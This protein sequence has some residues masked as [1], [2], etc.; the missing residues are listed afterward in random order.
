VFWAVVVIPGIMTTLLLAYPA[1]ERKLTGQDAAHNLLQRPRDAPARTA[2][3]MMAIT[4]FAVLLISGGDDVISYKLHFS[5]NA[6]TWVA[7]VALLLL[8]PLA[9]YLTYRLCL[10]LQRYDR[11][12]L[13]HG[14]E[15]GIIRRLPH[16]E[17]I[18]VHQ[19]L[20]A[21]DDHGHPLPLPYQGA[22]VPQRMNQL[23][24]AGKPLPGSL[25]RPD[26]PEETTAL[27]TAHDTNQ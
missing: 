18:E 15:T 8:P 2:L 23:G 25:Y 12:L 6:F 19:P 24:E 4:F 1:L 17:F 14:I 7:R 3:G 13:D 22:T 5:I 10:G 11:D 26:P 9:Y 21:V 16:G 27:H 20:G